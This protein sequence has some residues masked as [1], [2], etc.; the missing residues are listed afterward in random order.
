MEKQMNQMQE[1]MRLMQHQKP[2][3]QGT[4]T[5][6]ERQELIDAHMKMMPRILRQC[7]I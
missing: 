1:S 2:K 5:P 6:K 3:L 7:V 4:T